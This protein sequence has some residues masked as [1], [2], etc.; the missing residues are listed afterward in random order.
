MILQYENVCHS[1][2]FVWDSEGPEEAC[3]DCGE[4]EDIGTDN[5]DE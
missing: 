4:Q 1:C 5:I 3:P 2:G